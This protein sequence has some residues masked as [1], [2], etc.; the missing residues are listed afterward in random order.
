MNNIFIIG[1]KGVPAQYGGYETFVDELTKNKKSENIKY[2]V[3]CQ[4]AKEETFEY[5]STTCFNIKV[6]NIGPAK[7]ICY[8]IKAF[9]YCLRKIKNEKL[10]NAII[11]ILACRIG[12]FY[13]RL[14]K[15]AHKLGV[16]VFINPDGHEWK[17][18][19]WSAPVKK[20]W[21]ISEKLMV[22]YS[23][24]I[25]CDSV[26]I[27]KYINETYIKFNPNTSYVAYGAYK[28]PSLLNDDEPKFVNL[29]AKHN[30]SLKNYYL[31]VG[32]FVP[33]NNY[34]T[35]IREFM[36]S[37]TKKDLVLIT[38]Y[39]KNKF[40]KELEKK[41]HYS[42]DK[43]IKF[44]GTVYDK[45]LLKKI[46]ENA[47][48]YVHG[49]S[50]GGTNPSLLE[51]LASTNMNILYDVCFNKECAKASALYFSKEKHNLQYMIKLA[52]SF[53]QEEIEELGL[54]AK[55]EVRERYSWSYICQRYENI[56]EEGR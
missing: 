30:I 26:N 41:L 40:S 33:E 36:M 46:R 34:E 24:L 51:A 7:A 50:V 45:Q 55:N 22:K 29:L 48:A 23:D 8:D 54:K 16:K 47:F 21:K 39:S 1:S 9:K 10:E 35:I 32:R 19:K 15:K 13:K 2:Y 25:I 18:S 31:V 6:P 20:Y 37:D 11:Y 5:N 14:V 38:D 43:R 56:F 52:E 49:H 17:R 44:I 28:T 53:S 27:Q 4:N 42:S 12:P 3:A